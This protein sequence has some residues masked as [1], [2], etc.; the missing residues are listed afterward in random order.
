M[1]RI[2]TLVLALILLLSCAA[3]A[4]AEENKSLSV[5]TVAAGASFPDGVTVSDSDYLRRIEELTGFDLEWTTFNDASADGVRLLLS[6][7]NAP[8]LI[9]VADVG[10]IP[11]LANSGAIT[12]LNDAL[13]AVGAD[14]LELLPQEVLDGATIDGSIYFLPRY[15]GGGQIGTMALRKD[16]LDDLG[17]EVPGTIAE[18]EAVLA[19]VKENTDLTPLMVNSRLA[20][21]FMSFTNAFGADHTRSTYFYVV[22]GECRIPILG[23]NG[24]AFITKMNE[25]YNAGY[26]DREF[27]VVDGAEVTSNFFAG[28]G[29]AMFIDYTQ[30]ARQLPAFYE[31]NPDGEILIIDPPV[32]ENGE[33]GYTVDGTTS[34]AWFVPATSAGKVQLA[35]E[36]LNACLDEAVLNLIC[37]GIEGE[38]WEYVDGVPTFI[39]GH[40][41]VDY[42]GYYSRVVLDRTWDEAWEASMGLAEV[43]EQMQSYRKFNEILYIPV[44]GVEAYSENNSS[45]SGYINDEVIRMIAEGTSEEELADLYAEVMDMGG[46]DVIDQV[47]A[48]L[49]SK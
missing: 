8:D 39:E 41:P 13:E 6:S 4:T 14:L 45:I 47:N 36:F 25:W 12:P 5:I 27:L 46:Q 19:A 22:D 10:I 37:Y 42:R 18:W 24:L 30:V 38:N 11:E 21:S 28:N 1:K 7:G 26:I 31:K 34:M 29:F 23:E 20:G 35:V 15:T 2:L 17:L 16:V 43:V 32:G 40:S 44:E 48:W 3:F 9:Q 49:A 33:S